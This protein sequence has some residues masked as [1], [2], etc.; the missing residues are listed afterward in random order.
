MRSILGLVGTLPNM[1]AGLWGPGPAHSAEG[2]QSSKKSKKKKKENTTPSLCRPWSNRRASQ[3]KVLAR[4]GAHL[5]HF[6]NV[7]AVAGLLP[8][9]CCRAQAT[10][11]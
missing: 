5:R 1:N 11:N 3:S 8:G 9:D 4:S 10:S 2:A 7:S 6:G